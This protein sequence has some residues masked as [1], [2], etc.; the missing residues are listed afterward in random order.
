MTVVPSPELAGDRHRAARLM[1]EAMDLRQAEA[2][3]LADRLGGEERIEH[4]CDDVGRNADAGVLHGDRNIVAGR[5]WSR[6]P[7]R[8]FL[9]Q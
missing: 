7:R 1:G 8:V 2:G 9:D 5:H 6:F 4:A 3:A